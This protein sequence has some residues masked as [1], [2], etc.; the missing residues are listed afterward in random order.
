MLH[1]YISHIIL[2]SMLTINSTFSNWVNVTNVSEMSVLPQGQ[3][4]FDNLAVL[5]VYA[6]KISTGLLSAFWATA[7]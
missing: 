7:G 3:A 6:T 1:E 5:S 2:A 4:F